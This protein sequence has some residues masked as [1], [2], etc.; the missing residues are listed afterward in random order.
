MGNVPLVSSKQIAESL[1][2]LLPPIKAQCRS[3]SKPEGR[4]AI[5]KMWRRRP[6]KCHEDSVA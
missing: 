1:L 3:A 6:A 5:E 2:R 4:W